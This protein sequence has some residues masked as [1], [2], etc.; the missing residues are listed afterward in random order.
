MTT[1]THIARTSSPIQIEPR[2]QEA[3]RPAMKPK[4]LWYEVDGDWQ[5]WCND[6]GMDWRYGF[7]FR[8]AL[9]GER[10]LQIRTLKQLDAFDA[11]YHE[12]EHISHPGYGLEPYDDCRGIRWDQV[13][14]E[15]DGIEIAPYQWGRRLGGHIWYYSWDCASGVI[16]R[17]QGASLT[18]LK[19][20]V[21]A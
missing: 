1:L 12:L 18:L 11:R 9:D 15:W 16:W 7:L 4:G 10:M 21:P 20:L 14:E 5:R 2:P 6:E 8:L 17:P 19:E 13:A 3:G